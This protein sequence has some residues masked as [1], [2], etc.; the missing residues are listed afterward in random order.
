MGFED[1]AEQSIGRPCRQTNGG[2]RLLPLIRLVDR[3]SGT[4]PSIERVA[5]VV[6]TV[7]EEPRVYQRAPRQ[8]SKGLSGR[9]LRAAL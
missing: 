4:A 6:Q 2:S 1:E 8:G 7:R 5:P 3:R 9:L